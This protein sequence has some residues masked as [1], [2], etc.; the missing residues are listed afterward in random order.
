MRLA[1][2]TSEDMTGNPSGHL[3][4]IFTPASQVR[5]PSQIQNGG[6]Q[7]RKMNYTPSPFKSQQTGFRTSQ[8]AGSSSAWKRPADSQAIIQTRIENGTLSGLK[9]SVSMCAPMSSGQSPSGQSQ[10]NAV[11]SEAAP[12]HAECISP[13]RIDVAEESSHLAAASDLLSAA[14]LES[15]C[16]SSCRPKPRPGQPLA[17]RMRPTLWA[18][19]VG[20]AQ[21]RDV[22]RE[23]SSSGFLPS[24]ILWG[25]PGSQSPRASAPS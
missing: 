5:A 10:P 20:Q 17:D 9:R 19:F 13:V 6:K 25:P 16:S 24:M 11:I 2:N 14:A 21:V 4:A 23:L 22:L 3:A 7:S 1:R 18:D 12:R 8:H 15:E